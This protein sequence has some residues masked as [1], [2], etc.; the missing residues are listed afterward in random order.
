MSKPENN[1]A[2]SALGS[3]NSSSGGGQAAFGDHT[4]DKQKRAEYKAVGNLKTNKNQ[5]PKNPN[6]AS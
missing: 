4:E 5:N 2:P 6:N 1:K 3:E